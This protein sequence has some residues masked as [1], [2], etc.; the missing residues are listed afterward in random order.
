MASLK[1]CEVFKQEIRPILHKFFQQMKEELQLFNQYNLISQL[2]KDIIKK[3]QTNI[4]YDHICKIPLKYKNKLNTNTFTHTY[5]C[6]MNKGF[7]LRYVKM[8]QDYKYI[9]I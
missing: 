8:V 7:Y 6:I 3:I 9:L 1:F 2:T 4:C 5:R